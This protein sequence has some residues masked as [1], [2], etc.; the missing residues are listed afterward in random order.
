M[1]G[2]DVSCYGQT[3]GSASV[4]AFN[5]SGTYTYTWSNGINTPNN[6]GLGVGTYTVNVKDEVSGCTIIGAFVVGSPDPISMSTVITDVLCHGNFTGAINVTTIGGTASPPGDY[7]FSWS[8]GAST[9]DLTNIEAGNYQLNVVDDN[10]CTGSMIYTVIEPLEAIAG[11]A[12]V[13]D[14]LCFGTPTGTINL[15]VWGGTPAY[16]YVWNSGQSTQDISNLGAAAYSVAITDLNG[17]TLN[18][19]YNIGQPAV[20]NGTIG[21]T[22][23]LCFG[24]STGV[25]YVNP[26]GGTTPYSYEWQN[27]VNLFA[28]NAATLTNV[29]ADAYQV[30]VTDNNGCEYVDVVNVLEPAELLLTN[31]YVDVSCYG[32]NNGA[33]NLTVTGGIPAY[34]YTWT[35]SLG[36]IVGTSQDLLTLVAEIYSVEVVD[37]NGCIA[38]LTQEIIQPNLPIST[39][40]DVVDVLCFGENTGE[41][42]LTASGGTPP[43]SFSW[44]SG[45]STEDILNMLAGTYGYTVID[46]NGCVETGSAFIDQPL[47]PLDVTFI[48]TDVNCFGES[49]GSIDLTVTGGTAPYTFTWTNSTYSLSYTQ[50]DLINFV[51]DSY[52]FEVTDAN[53][54]TFADTLEINQP[55]EIVLTLNPTHVLCYGEATGSI[56]LTVVGGVAPYTYLW[57]TGFTTE[58]LSGL[59]AGNYSV[60]V[61]DDHN[62]DM[63]ASITINQP[64]D[65][66]SFTFDVFDVECNNGTNGEIDL[67][68]AGGTPPYVYS[69][70]NGATISSIENLT[71]GYYAFTV[72][73][74]NGCVFQDSI[75]VNQPDPFL[76]NEVITPVSCYGGSDGAIDI[77]PT[78]GTPPFAYSWFNSTFALAEQAQDLVDYVA[79]VYQLEIVDSNGCFYEMFMEITQPDSLIINYTI[80]PVTCYGW[81][82]GA[83]DVTITGGNPPYSFT[84]SNGNL[85][86]D[87][88]DVVSDTFQM[89]VLDTKGCTD[90]LTQLVPQPDT[91]IIVFEHDPA[92]CIDAADGVGYAYPQGGNGGYMYDWSNGATTQIATGFTNDYHYLTVTDV[93]GCVATDTLYITALDAPCL[94][95]PNAF[96]PNGDV[97]NDDWR[98]DNFEF[99]PDAH[100]QVFNKW[101]NKIHEQIGV[102]EP[103]DGTING[104]PAPS[105]TYY[106]IIHVNYLDRESVRGNVTILR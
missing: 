28:I 103:W 82:D 98:I 27:S 41:I 104:S 1:S 57:N 101:G 20:L 74:F 100:L 40:T 22:D 73:D 25:A 97:Y 94:D 87:L 45:Q 69:W 17:C 90:T 85:T 4:F 60:T 67:Y 93:L 49:N 58:D 7:S 86:E 34:N 65:T 76:A 83:I 62:C 51:A 53:G 42:D 2:T 81:S 26:T 3:D 6:P 77:T 16:S 55:D 99:Y 70:T 80:K 78:G 66:M 52:R 32:G 29:P 15:S 12:I 105:D 68:M 102:Y 30:T 24:E 39:T 89:I 64:L 71:A 95:P 37:N 79:D 88:I 35:N 47:A 48:I 33:I 5:G 44:T 23:V 63:S 31:T 38:N 14:A 75:R 46:N 56:D 18:L 84:W 11:S 10:G 91:L 13:S 21:S 72:T 106:W 43:F 36:A 50:E 59:I 54:C 96:T 19:A 8:N 92:S 9:E 61:T